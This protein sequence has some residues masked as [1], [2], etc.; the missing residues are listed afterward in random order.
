MIITGFLGLIKLSTLLIPKKFHKSLYQNKNKNMNIV[1]KKIGIYNSEIL[2]IGQSKKGP[3]NNVKL[4][5]FSGN[6]S[7]VFYYSKFLD[8]LY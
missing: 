5:L 7:S 6:P 4:V 1:Y 2:N 3:L 8:T